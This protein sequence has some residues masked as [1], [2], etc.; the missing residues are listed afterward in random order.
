MLVNFIPI[1]SEEETMLRLLKEHRYV[2]TW[3]SVVIGVIVLFFGYIKYRQ[4]GQL[5]LDAT[6]EG[7]AIE[8]VYSFEFVSYPKSIE[9][10]LMQSG[11]MWVIKERVELPKELS[12]LS[13]EQKEKVYEV[14]ETYVNT[15]LGGV[16]GRYGIAKFDGYSSFSI[17]NLTTRTLE[18]VTLQLPYFFRIASFYR[19]GSGM[20]ELTEFSNEIEFGEFRPQEALTVTAWLDKVPTSY[21][22]KIRILHRNGVGKVYE[23]KRVVERD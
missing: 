17:R 22:E 14:V 7:P 1:E 4:D 11:L 2:A 18:D 16:V 6:S 12:A 15:Q 3:I 5:G 10:V 19:D 23:S 9:D 21:G 20:V 8:V 13:N